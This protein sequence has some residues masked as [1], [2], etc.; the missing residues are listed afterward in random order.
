M[1]YLILSL[2]LWTEKRNSVYK[3]QFKLIKFIICFVDTTTTSS[4]PFPSVPFPLI[5]SP[6]TFGREDR[7]HWYP[8]VYPVYAVDAN[9]AETMVSI[10]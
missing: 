5:T 1:Y 7:E 4:S 8:G 2:G 10:G 6:S 3:Q 9:V